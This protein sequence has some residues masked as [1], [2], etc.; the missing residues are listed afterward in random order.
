MENSD[1][2]TKEGELGSEN[3]TNLTKSEALEI[4][5]EEKKEQER[6]TV[7]KKLFLEYFPKSNLHIGNTCKT[8]GIERQTYYNWMDADQ[9]FND[10]VENVRKTMRD[11]MEDVL[12]GLALVE[13]DGPSVRYWL[14]RKHPAYTPKSKVET[15]TGKKTLEDLLDEHEEKENDDT[16]DTKE[17]EQTTGPEIPDREIIQ[18][19]KQE[20]PDSAVQ[21][22]HG[23]EVLL[24]KE[25]ETQPNS[26]SETK[27]NIQGNRRRP[28]AR[29]HQERY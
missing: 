2:K 19:Q 9:E 1:N 21:I 4:T 27:G 11:E 26:E 13:K 16:T 7:N 20:G 6:T 12:I 29:L 25:N 28:I 18:D 24:E 22:Q 14:D 17:N 8:I 10:A 5:E 15:Y 3:L 23:A